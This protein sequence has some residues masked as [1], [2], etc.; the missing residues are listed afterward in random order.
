MIKIEL[1]F[2]IP[3]KAPQKSGRRFYNPRSEEKNQCQWIIRS[4]Y[5]GPLLHGAIREIICFEIAMPESWSKKKRE[6]MLRM[7]HTQTPDSD[8]CEKFTHD[9]LKKIVI[10][11]DCL[12]WDKH[13]KK[14]WQ[15]KDKTIIYLW[16]QD[17]E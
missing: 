8:N 16:Q 10:A 2:V 5:S 1:P 3:F 13:T 7:P 4:Q 17:Q 15:E 14:Y 9:V 6:E 11:D 12:I